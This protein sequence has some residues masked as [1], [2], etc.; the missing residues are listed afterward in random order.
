MRVR[1]RMACE[2]GF[3]GSVHGAMSVTICGERM[4]KVMAA[5]TFSW[6]IPV[7]MTRR[8]HGA[9]AVAIPHSVNFH[10][11]QSRVRRWVSCII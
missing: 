11:C 2:V 9:L 7:A 10:W 1:T 3:A 5:L 8:V 4:M 6:G